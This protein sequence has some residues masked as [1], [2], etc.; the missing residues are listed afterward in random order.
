MTYARIRN[1]LQEI[2]D[3]IE[4]LHLPYE[5]EFRTQLK[6]LENHERHI[7]RDFF[8]AQE[9]N[10]GSTK[11]L[12]ALRAT[13]ILITSEYI[14]RLHS[15]ELIQRVMNDLLEAEH[16][17]LAELIS[18]SYLDISVE[19]SQIVNETISLALDDLIENPD[20]VSCNYL[21]H[22]RQFLESDEIYKLRQ[23]HLTLLLQKGPNN[24]LERSIPL[25]TEW[26]QQGKELD[27]SI[28]CQILKE[29]IKDKDQTLET[30][31]SFCKKRDNVSWR[32]FLQILRLVSINIGN[33]K[34]EIL[35]IKG[36][37]KELFG[38]MVDTMNFDLFLLLIAIVR[39]ISSANESVVGKYSS[40]YKTTLGEMSYR[41]SKEQFVGVLGMMT[42]LVP[43]ETDSEML[44]VHINIS[45]SAPPKCMEL[46]VTYKQMCRAH[47]TKLNLDMSK[48]NQDMDVSI[49]IDD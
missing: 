47:L 14:L 46:V 12:A 48:D 16:T 42:R 38:E 27:S 36:F 5:E 8:L 40:W 17:L 28:F 30:M 32:F 26:R 20:I 34:V 4:T 29:V 10:L 43:L 1:I 31:F 21:Q 45:I 11:V 23:Q 18:Y 33:D 2:T 41:F 13:G 3:R 25:Q 9:W 22:V 44:T 39:E 7:I 24:D 15:K 37:L 35:R 49:V 6:Y 19:L